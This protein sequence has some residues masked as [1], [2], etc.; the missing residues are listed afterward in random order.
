V[1][2]KSLILIL[3]AGSLILTAASAE[4]VLRWEPAPAIVWI[5]D[6][7]TISIMLDEPLDVR[8]FEVFVAFDPE[9][10]ATVSGGP[11]ALFAGFN[12]FAGFAETQPGQWHGYCVILG[13][14]VWTTGP[15]ELFSITVA[16]LQAGISALTTVALTLLPPGGGQYPDVELP[17]G[18]IHVVDPTGVPA[19]RGAAQLEVYP[20]P[21]NPRTTI[22]FE[23][24]RSAQASVTIHDLA[25]R[26]VRT[27]RRG[28]LAASRHQVVWDGI[29]DRGD[30]A[31]SGVYVV[32]LTT[33]DGARQAVK[34]TL[35]R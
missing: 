24:P 30:R 22:W 3:A 12:T 34:I 7:A 10:I 15:G 19:H 2:G 13:A 23:L 17:A 6:E 25:G 8:T 5:D 35:T 9:L 29:S 21:C 26:L 32:R 28:P 20:N 11:G 31:A 33:S 1:F 27:L 14:E 18:A 16:G 4:P